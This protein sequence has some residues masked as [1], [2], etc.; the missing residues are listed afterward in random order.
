MKQTDVYYARK[1]ISKE[2][3]AKDRG[4]K[5]TLTFQGFR[6]LMT[7]KY[8][9]YTGIALSDVDGAADQRTIDRVNANKGYESGNVVA[10]CKAFNQMKGRMEQDGSI[11]NPLFQ[12]AILK[13]FKEV[14]KRTNE[15]KK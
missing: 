8:C 12:K 7:A 4:I 1:F 3:G 10:C 14:N 13:M 11:F 6:N 2:Q 9:Y 15:A 5:F